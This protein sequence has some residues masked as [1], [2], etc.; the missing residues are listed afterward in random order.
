MIRVK[1]VRKGYHQEGVELLGPNYTPSDNFFGAKVIVAEDEP[2][3]RDALNIGLR[4]TVPLII[5]AVIDPAEYN[6]II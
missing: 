4:G 2:A 3:F 5:E 1:Q 6:H